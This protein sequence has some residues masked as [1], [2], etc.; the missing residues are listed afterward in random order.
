MQTER[1]YSI[2]KEH[3][4]VQ[5]DTRALAKG[6]LFFALKGPNFNGN[7][8]ASRALELG[9]VAVVVDE[10][11]GIKNEKVIQVED[12]LTALQLL[13]LHHRKQRKNNYKRI[14]A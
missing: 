13:A 1:L 14:G 10:D 12:V 2:F 5:T 8:F 9:A 7:E 6:Q 4:H 3:P 11:T